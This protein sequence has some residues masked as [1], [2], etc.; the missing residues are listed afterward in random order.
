MVYFYGLLL[1]RTC[2]N[3]G[4]I[5]SRKMRKTEVFFFKARHLVH[6]KALGVGDIESIYI[7]E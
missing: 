6:Q 2:E 3:L 5:P 1:F 4:T 7:F